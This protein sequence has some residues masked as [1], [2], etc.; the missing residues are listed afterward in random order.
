MEDIF[1]GNVL[2]GDVFENIFN[3]NNYDNDNNDNN[4]DNIDYYRIED[5]VLIKC[6][7]VGC[8]KIWN[9]WDTLEIVKHFHLEKEE[10]GHYNNQ[11]ELTSEK[12]VVIC[13]D[14]KK[15]YKS[16]GGD[17]RKSG[18]CFQDH[19]KIMGLITWKKG[20]DYFLNNDEFIK[21]P[22]ENYIQTYED[23]YDLPYNTQ[24]DFY[25]PSNSTC[26]EQDHKK[27]YIW[28]ELEN[29]VEIQNDNNIKDNVPI[30]CSLVGCRK[31][32]SEWNTLEIVKH[33]YLKKKEGGHYENQKKLASGERVVICADC[34]KIY[35]SYN[36]GFRKSGKCFQDHKEINDLITWKKGQDYI[37]K[38]DEF[39][40]CPIE[41]CTQTWNKDNS[42]LL[43]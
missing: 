34:K 41:G 32:W 30:K 17:F 12:R 22:I 39:I 40:K 15:I 8:S 19:K 31:I 16:Y 24:D 38:N 37:L 13:A 42:A 33:F 9:E 29:P 36:D 23:S 3:D 5:N 6:P 25:N 4:Y 10:G 26:V 21:H 43:Q 2:I 14:C 1:L 7:L 11:K 35:K 20:Q 27:C 28:T 18:K